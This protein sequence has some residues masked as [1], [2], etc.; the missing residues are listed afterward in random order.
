MSERV[1]AIHQP[2]FLPWLGYFA[3]IAKADVFVFLDD[4]QFPKKGGTWINRVKIL[5]KGAAHWV[6]APV[7]RAYSGTRAICHMQFSNGQN[8]RDKTISAL[9]TAYGRSPFFNELMPHIEPLVRNED[10]GIAE[11]NINAVRALVELIGLNEP[12]FV[13]SSHLNCDSFGTDRLIDITKKNQGS[14][15]LCGNGADGYQDDALFSKM[16]IKLRYNNFLCEP[17]QQVRTQGFVPRL[18]VIDALFH[19]GPAG[20]QALLR[21]R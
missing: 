18:S 3:K 15:Y 13:R 16:G 14:I 9:T 21:H 4:A 1:V 8:W 19:V 2:N 17:Y 11:H 5:D 12:E 6:T 10:E 20:V 7:D